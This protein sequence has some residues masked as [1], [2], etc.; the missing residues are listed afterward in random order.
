MKRSYLV[1]NRLYEREGICDRES[2]FEDD[3]DEMELVELAEELLKKW[4][5]I[6]RK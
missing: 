5:Q 6:W 1:G 2:I 3:Q 4:A